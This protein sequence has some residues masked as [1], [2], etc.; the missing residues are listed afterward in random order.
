MLRVEEASKS[1]LSVDLQILRKRFER[2]E[3]QLRDAQA[4]FDAR[5]AAALAEERER[6]ALG[7]GI[8]EAAKQLVRDSGSS[9][10]GVGSAVGSS[11][12]ASSRAASPKGGAAKLERQQSLPGRGM[13]GFL[14]GGGTGQL[15]AGASAGANTLRGGGG[16]S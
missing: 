9:G 12:N 1:K 10:A 16:A 14:R 13:G 11:S 5:L 8:A 4:G 2:K 3:T 7:A 15:A 6:A